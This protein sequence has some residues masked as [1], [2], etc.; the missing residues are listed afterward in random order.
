MLVGGCTGG[1]FGEETNLRV[2]M[3]VVRN[4]RSQVKHEDACAKDT[5]TI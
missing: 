5:Y 1:E 4:M 3:G 2:L